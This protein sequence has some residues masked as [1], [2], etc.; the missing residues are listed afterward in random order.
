VV[1][2]AAEAKETGRLEA[3]SDGV[4]AIAVTLLVLELKVPVL[5]TDKNSAALAKALLQQ[6]PGYVGLVTSFFRGIGHVGASPCDSPERLR[7][8]HGVV[9]FLGNDDYEEYAGVMPLLELSEA[10]SLAPPAF[11]GQGM[12]MTTAESR[13]P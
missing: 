12:G 13:W 3:F 9:D 10:G 5:G 7:D 2:R 8:L 1:N 4:F 6:W 11:G